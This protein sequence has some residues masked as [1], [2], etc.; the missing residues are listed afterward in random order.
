MFQNISKSI[1]FTVLAPKFQYEPFLTISKHSD[2]KCFLF[3]FR[4]VWEAVLEDEVDEVF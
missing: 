3:I 2:L 4:N 1:I